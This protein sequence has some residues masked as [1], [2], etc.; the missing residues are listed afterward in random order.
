MFLGFGQVNSRDT[1]RP[2]ISL[3]TSY[4]LDLLSLPSPARIVVGQLF[5]KRRRQRKFVIA[6]TAEKR[7]RNYSLFV[8]RHL[9]SRS[10]SSD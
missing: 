8:D 9:T 10:A 1:L 4:R 5:H 7:K 3:W 2:M 6:V